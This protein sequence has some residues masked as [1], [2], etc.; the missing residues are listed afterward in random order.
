MRRYEQVSGAVFALIA[1]VQ[2]TRAVFGWPAQVAGF[3]IPVWFSGV[4][5]AVTGSLAIWAFRVH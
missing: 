2:L 5:F 4:A 3:S 1:L